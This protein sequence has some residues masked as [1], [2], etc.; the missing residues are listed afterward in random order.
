MGAGGGLS[1]S[2][3]RKLGAAGFQVALAAR[4]TGKLAS[5][6]GETGAQAFAC[7]AAMPQDVARLFD[8]VA[9]R[10]GAVDV[11]VYNSSGRARGQLVE[12]DPAE[13]QRTLAVTAFGGF[14]V[15]Q[16]LHV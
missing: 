11:V 4:D 13:V 16:P 10:L 12:L 7:N 15:G 14:L 9:A 1:G 8:E 3:A 2:L 5:L 6:V